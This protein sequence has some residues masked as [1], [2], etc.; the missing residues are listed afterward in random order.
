MHVI[1][2]TACP[3][4]T[5]IVIAIVS[6]DKATKVAEGHLS[7]GGTGNA[8]CASTGGKTALWSSGTMVS[9]GTLTLASGFYWVVIAADSAATKVIKAYRGNGDSGTNADHE[10]MVNSGSMW[11][12]DGATSGSGG[13]L[14]VTVPLGSTTSHY[15]ISNPHLAWYF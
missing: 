3:A 13:S 10:L 9:S 4:T 7:N 2:S 1:V 14:S 6:A 12:I 8:D 15:T 5:G 11:Y